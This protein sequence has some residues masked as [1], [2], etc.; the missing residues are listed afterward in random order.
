MIRVSKD[1]QVRALDVSEKTDNQGL[2]RLDQPTGSPLWA[3]QALFTPLDGSKPEVISVTIAST[4]RPEVVPLQSTF[5]E[6]R[7]DKYQIERDGK[8][9]QCGKYYRAAGLE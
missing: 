5:I 2:Q 9:T 7:V 8:I 6:L 1:E 4:T 3:V